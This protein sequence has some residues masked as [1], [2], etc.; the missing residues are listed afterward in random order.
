MLATGL[1]FWVEKRRYRKKDSTAQ[2]QGFRF[3][4]GGNYGVLLGLPIALVGYLWLNR[5]IPA[6]FDSRIAFEQNGFF[7]LLAMCFLYGV[8]IPAHIARRRLLQLLA[9][10]CLLLPFMSDVLGGSGVIS[11]LLKGDKTMLALNGIL[12]ITACTSI[13]TLNSSSFK[14]HVTAPVSA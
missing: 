9:L 13:F 14:K 1:V 10:L 7:V 3:I 12:L 4:E 11:S 5:L 8:I 6:S 2:A